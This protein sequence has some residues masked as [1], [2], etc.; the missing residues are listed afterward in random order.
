MRSALAAGAVPLLLLLLA[1]ATLLTRYWQPQSL[2]WDENYHIASAQK[3]LDGVMYMEPHPPL[4]KMLIALGEAAVG[5]NRGLDTSAL[6][7][8]DHITNAQ[9]P[10]DFSYRG[11]RLASV[12]LTVLAVLLAYALLL[13][14]TGLRSLAG[15]FAALLALDNALVVHTR[16]A[17]LEGMQIFFV[18]LALYLL[19]CTVSRQSAVRLRDYVRLAAAIGLAIA[20]KVNAAVLLLLLVA[21]Y[22]FD[23]WPTLQRGDWR[24]AAQRLAIT[25][26]TATACVLAVLLAVFYLHIVTTTTVMP[27][28]TYKASPAYL[29]HLQANTAWTPAGFA[30]GL[31]DHWRYMREYSTGVPVLDVCK[32]G[33]NGSAASSWPLGAKAINYRWNKRV[34]DGRA[35]VEY[36][37]LLANPVVWWSVLA[38]I[39]LSSALIIGRVVFGHPVHDARLFAW[40]SMLTALYVS[41]LLAITQIDRVMYLY[42]YLLPLSIGVLNLGVLYA[43]LFGDELRRG[44]WHAR[45]N[46]C[47][48]VLLAAGVFGFFAPL[49]YGQPLTAE[50]VELRQWMAAWKIEP[51]R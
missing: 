35:E 1:C 37:Y 40:L 24:G 31:A 50:Q 49:T 41:Y 34:R 21:L 33:E 9:L 7:S 11:V 18:M 39:L 15:G 25:A 13:K 17:M 2:F 30:T 43:Y 28:R 19:A 44:R 10:A 6:L 4:G 23:T 20:I 8:R 46:L 47:A 42:H 26:P 12:I 29:G 38:G 14:V 22:L 27:G 36:T 16:A 32:P 51:I 3:H 5:D 45:L 48:F